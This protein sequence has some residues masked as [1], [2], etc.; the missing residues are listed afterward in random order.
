LAA[1]VVATK[2]AIG[3]DADGFFLCGRSGPPA[4]AALQCAGWHFFMKLFFAAPDSFFSVAAV[5]Q[6]GSAA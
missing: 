5:K 1:Q 6:R 4:V 2:K 3:A